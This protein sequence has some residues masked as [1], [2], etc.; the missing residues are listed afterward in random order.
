MEKSEHTDFNEDNT[1]ESPLVW[2]VVMYG[3]ESWTLMKN[4]ETR[5]EAFEMKGCLLYTSDAAD[6]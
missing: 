1:N 3:C 4:E 5:F 2:P 6:E